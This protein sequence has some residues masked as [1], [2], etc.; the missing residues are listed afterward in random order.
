MEREG[1]RKA[2][3]LCKPCTSG[4]PGGENRNEE[5]VKHLLSAEAPTKCPALVNSPAA[6]PAQKP[7]TPVH[8]VGVRSQGPLCPSWRL[9][10]A[11]K[12]RYGSYQVLKSLTELDKQR[13]DPVAEGHRTVLTWPGQL[14]SSV[15]P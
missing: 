10:L 4:N 2:G 12:N 8:V 7:G 11:C 14:L 15:V 6:A 3:L 13:S 1:D 5:G 9:T